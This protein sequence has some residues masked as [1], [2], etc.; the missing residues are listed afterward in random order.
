MIHIKNRISIK[1]K[2]F[3]IN[4]T[5][6]F[7]QYISLYC[8]CLLF[9]LIRVVVEFKFEGATFRLKFNAEKFIN[10]LIKFLDLRLTVDVLALVIKLF[11]Y[12]FA[13]IVLTFSLSFLLKS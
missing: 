11:Y 8:E 13:F 2:H 4:L 9:F 7:I 12:C 6:L 1:L 3:N 5:Y 10:P